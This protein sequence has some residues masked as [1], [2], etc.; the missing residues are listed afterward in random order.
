MLAEELAD[1]ARSVPDFTGPYSSEARPPMSLVTPFCESGD[2]H[3]AEKLR[4]FA[5]GEDA[6]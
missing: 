5:R 4:G 2:S 3:A 6:L 1:G